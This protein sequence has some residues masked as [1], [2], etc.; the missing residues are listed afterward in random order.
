MQV[1]NQTK[2]ADNDELTITLLFNNQ[3]GQNCCYMGNRSRGAQQVKYVGNTDAFFFDFYFMSPKWTDADNSV[4]TGLM[5]P[6][7][8]TEVLRVPLHIS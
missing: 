8:C 1:N 3:T 5:M 7:A 6:T 4:P 2:I